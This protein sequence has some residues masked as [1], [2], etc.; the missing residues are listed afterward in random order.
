MIVNRMVTTF[1]YSIAVR[2]IC[3][4]FNNSLTTHKY[5]NEYNDF[6]PT[7]ILGWKIM[8]W[9]F[10]LSM[11]GSAGLVAIGSTIRCLPLIVTVSDGVFTVLVHV[12]AILN[13]PPGIIG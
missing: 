4:N 10:R 3:I 1:I 13:A 11:V 5:L 8:E 7:L 9:N 2:K 12:G 6:N